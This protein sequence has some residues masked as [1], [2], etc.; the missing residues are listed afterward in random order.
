VAAGGAPAGEGGVVRRLV[1]LALFA[2]APAQADG[3]ND[4]GRVGEVALVAAAL[5]KTL[6][7]GDGE[8]GRQLAFNFGTTVAATEALKRL[9]GSERPNGRDDRSFPSGHSSISFSAAGHLH[10][11]YGWEWGAPALVAAAFVGWSRV[12][13][14]EHRWEDVAAGALLGTA[15]AHLFTTRL[16]D[17][18]RLLP[19][20]GTQ[21]GGLAARVAF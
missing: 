3:W 14:N 2:A 6:A 20:G 5:G 15:S 10:A 18:V 19:W 11:R 8:G 4:A 21:G 12:E 7:E 9:V 16:D 13:A 17:R 1:V